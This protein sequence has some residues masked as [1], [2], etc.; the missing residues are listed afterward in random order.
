MQVS[1]C[2]VVDQTDSDYITVPRIAI[3]NDTVFLQAH[4]TA[5]LRIYTDDVSGRIQYL[6][7]ADPDRIFSPPRAKLTDE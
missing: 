7:L 4:L 1:V 5:N 6:A 3:L 2:R